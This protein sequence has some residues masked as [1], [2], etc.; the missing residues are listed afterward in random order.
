M[1]IC[2]G[3]WTHLNSHH[4]VEMTLRILLDDVAHIVRFSRLL[5]FSTCDKIFDFAY[6]PDGVAMGL[7]QSAKKDMKKNIFEKK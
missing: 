1:Q 4:H 5:E 3:V 2:R 7:S 6:R